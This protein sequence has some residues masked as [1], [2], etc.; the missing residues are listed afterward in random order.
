MYIMYIY[1]YIYLYIIYNGP[2]V[3][4]VTWLCLLRDVIYT[5]YA[6]I[7]QSDEDYNTADE[8]HLLILLAGYIVP[9]YYVCIIKANRHI[10]Q[11][12]I[13]YLNFACIIS[14]Q[15]GNI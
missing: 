9:S 14:G 1:I 13:Y 12:H 11:M 4:T 2:P 3:R 8:G 10:F 6:N 15:Y 7:A 5:I